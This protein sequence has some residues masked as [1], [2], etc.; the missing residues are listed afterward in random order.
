MPERGARFREVM[1]HRAG[2]A[3]IDRLNCTIPERGVTALIGPNGAGKSLTLRLLAGLIRPDSG[4]VLFSR[5]RPSP[6]RMP[7]VFQQPMLLRRRVRANLDHVLAAY[8]VPR[9]ERAARRDALL[10]EGGLEDLADSPA[11]KLSGG[12]QQRLALVRA[13]AAEPE[14]LLLDEPTAS[15][16]PRSTAMIETLVR[17]TAD[18]GGA[19]ILVT[20]DRAQARRLADHVLLLHKGRLA[21]SGPTAEIFRQPQTGEARAYLSGE[22]LV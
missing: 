3:V 19:V 14:Y 4:E 22:L 8:G 6:Q 12:E 18:R 13:L 15:L 10:A 1:L 7:V 5:M 2:R 16:D 11:R 20:H 21:E 17:R 9:A